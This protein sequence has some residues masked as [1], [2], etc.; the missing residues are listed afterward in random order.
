MK[1]STRRGTGRQPDGVA[2]A[3]DFAAFVQRSL[4]PNFDLG[5][6]KAMGLRVKDDP[7]DKPYAQHAW[8]YTAVKAQADALAQVEFVIYKRQGKLPPEDK[9]R[10]AIASAV[11]KRVKA[12]DIERCAAVDDS[13][14]RLRE[15][16]RVAP[17][18]RPRQLAA[19]V[20]DAVRVES[21]PWVDLFRR[22][23]PVLTRA[24][25]WEATIVNRNVTGECFWLLEGDGDQLAGEKDV[26]LEIWPM[27]PPGWKPKIDKRQKVPVSWELTLR[28]DGGQET[29]R[30]VE[31]HQLVHWRH[32]NPYN[33]VRGLAPIDVLAKVLEAD[34]RA[35][36]FN[37]A[38]FANGG[39]PGGYILTEKPLTP[40]QEQ[41]LQEQFEA[42][43][44]GEKKAGR[45]A[46]FSGGVKYVETGA[47]HREMQYQAMKQWNRDVALAVQRTPRSVVGL[48]EDVNRATAL[49][50]Q[51][52]FWETNL[53]PQAIYAEDLLEGD[54]FTKERTGDLI[55]GA[56][57][58]S[59]VE[60]LNPDFNE[61]YPKMSAAKGFIELGWSPNQV[62][63]ALNLGMPGDRPEAQLGV[64]TLA[65]AVT[66]IHEMARDVASGL[67]PHAAA[68]EQLVV[69][70]GIDKAQALRLIGPEPEPLP[71]EDPDEP[72]EPA[73]PP[74]P[75]AP[76]PGPAAG[77]SRAAKEEYWEDLVA[78]V[79]KPG[80]AAF[81]K[82]FRTFLYELRKA[83]LA[84]IDQR[85]EAVSSSETVLF[86]L[87][88]WQQD[89]WER[90]RPVYE[91]VYDDAREHISEELDRLGKSAAEPVKRSEHQ[92]LMR[93]LNKRIAGTVKTIRGRLQ[94]V[95]DEAIERGA[96][97]AALK[98][99]VRLE[100]SEIASGGKVGVIARTEVSTT[101]SGA[102][103]ITMRER[104]V[105]FH[106]WITAG[107]EYVRDTHV[108]YGD[109]GP[110]EIGKSWAS[111]LGASYTLRYPLDRKAPMGETINCRCVAVPTS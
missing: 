18:L 105:R 85:G 33:P 43:H 44:R 28:D 103:D 82:R 22:P 50:S 72:D 2:R 1:R 31:L 67:L 90:E 74:P 19:A 30:L 75:P 54:L 76:A 79:F 36:L 107:D 41:V 49:A 51:A 92:R 78:R 108:V 55:W 71:E 12:V 94:R 32:Y 83:Q 77:R 66:K 17:W 11:G 40:Q 80:E 53:I 102:R 38:F 63:D 16:R 69:L 104:D 20:G 25:L 58:L 59:V 6:F 34:F 13:K 15:I 109:A 70:Y 87:R 111:L 45:P 89:V 35:D 60:A 57:D 65:P 68:L 9:R 73:P 4:A 8:I 42:R 93:G 14:L 37:L 99:M 24:Q 110:L 23:N 100:F 48:V 95:L 64:G 91:K 98:E 106:E 10:D 47:S 97:K 27:G 56:F 86:D 21:G 101:V 84:L 26:P 62:N 46:V 39:S 52:N 5:F 61:L 96:D 7:F 29:K 81:D 3:E 88:E